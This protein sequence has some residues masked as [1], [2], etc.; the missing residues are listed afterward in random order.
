MFAPK[1][2]PDVSGQ[3]TAHATSARSRKS[4]QF[5]TDDDQSRRQ[6]VD[7]LDVPDFAKFW[8]DDAKRVEDAVHSIGRVQG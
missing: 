2:T 5:K 4:D 3:Q 8:D 6:E 1:G 7:Y